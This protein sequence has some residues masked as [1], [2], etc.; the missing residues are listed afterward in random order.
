VNVGGVTMLT[1]DLLR[2]RVK[3]ITDQHR[4]RI[5]K[6]YGV[7]CDP[8][9]G[10]KMKKQSLKLPAKTIEPILISTT[11]KKQ[12]DRADVLLSIF[13]LALQD[14]HS[15][16]YID[17]SIQEL[18]QIAVDH[19]VLH[20]FAKVLF[21][22]CT[23]Q[24]P[25][26]ELQSF[27]T[28]SEVRQIAF[29][30][31]TKQRKEQSLVSIEEQRTEILQQ[32]VLEI[33]KQCK[34]KTTEMPDT[35]H[36]TILDMTPQI[37]DAYLYADLKEN[38]VVGEMDKNTPT[39]PLNLIYRYNL[40]LCQSLLLRA[41]EMDI[42][43]DFSDM[44]AV[45]SQEKKDIQNNQIQGNTLQISKWLRY[46]F[47]H[48]KFQQLMYRIRRVHPENEYSHL[49]HIRIDGPQSIFQKSSR[50]GMQLALFL[51]AL[52]LVPCTW[53]TTSTVLW[54]N[55][56]KVK[57]L[58]CL[59][60]KNNLKSHY[61]PTG[62]WRSSAEEK[63]EIRFQDWINKE[64]KKSHEV[65]WTLEPGQIFPLEDG[66]LCISDF[67]LSH[68]LGEVHVEILGYWK[69]RQMTQNKRR[70]KNTNYIL[71]VSKKLLSDKVILKGKDDEKQLYKKG[72]VVFSE[73]IP[74]KKIM[75][76]ARLYLQI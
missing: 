14:R 53:Y 29:Y 51:P 18:T 39:T 10:Q 17:S 2:V 73:V 21:D 15:R 13:A 44:I 34:Q 6:I 46:L 71:V 54:G 19:K 25:S 28:P 64:K 8:A 63:F 60:S 42:Y 26:L 48:I 76:C 67:L 52:V 58:F 22:R 49:Y 35:I 12:L 66:N 43:I 11:S 61:K 59:S 3:N 33:Q 41:T 7:F 47:R 5:E 75:D 55:K 38:H 70:P 23:F 68:P 62:I 27:I 45:R 74:I 56:R 24:S 72:I 1:G 9:T 69:K 40:S 31:A 36:Q 65:Q 50:Y 16:Q 37:V 32:V 4:D 57:R 30:L 20:G